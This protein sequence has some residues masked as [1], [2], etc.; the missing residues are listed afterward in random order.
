MDLKDIYRTFHPKAAE[1]TF[2]LSAHRTFSRIEHIL[3]LCQV[4]VNLRKVKSHQASFPTMMLYNWKSITRKKKPAKNTN[5]WETKQHATK[6]LM[7][8]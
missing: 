1:Y 3:G 8:H 7:D 6:K 4:S 5:T 2:F